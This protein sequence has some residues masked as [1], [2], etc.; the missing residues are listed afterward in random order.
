MRNYWLK[1]VEE[2]NIRDIREH[3]R[4]TISSRILGLITKDRAEHELRKVLV[5]MEMTDLSDDVIDELIEELERL[6]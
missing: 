1:R 4:N 3:L 2:N 6:L 5:F